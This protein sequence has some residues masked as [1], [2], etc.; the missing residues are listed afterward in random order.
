MEGMKRNKTVEEF[1][2]GLETFRPEIERLRAILS[3]TALEEEV[4]WGI[5]TYTYRGKNVVGLAGFKEHFAIWFHQG[6]LLSDPE[7][8]LVNASEGK[9]KALRQWRFKSAKEIKVRPIKAYVKEAIA[10]VESGTEIKPE[11]G[12]PVD[13]PPELESALA[14]SAT[15]RRA[16]DAL[17][18]GKR[19]EYANHV[20]EAKRAETKEKRVKKILPMIRAGGGLHD[21]YR[22][23]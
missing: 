7:G 6:A 18:P 20:A 2:E 11:R 4:K 12:K 13:I 5:P 15:A 17:T 1:L 14:K 23:C 22:N 10:V 21:K 8:V 19:R 3:S 16:F 9:T